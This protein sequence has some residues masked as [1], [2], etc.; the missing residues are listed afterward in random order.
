RINVCPFRLFIQC[1]QYLV[2]ANP[3]NFEFNFEIFVEVIEKYIIGKNIFDCEGI[4][5]E[6]AFEKIVLCKYIYYNSTFNGKISLYKKYEDTIELDSYEAS[7]CS[8]R[9]LNGLHDFPG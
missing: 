9:K 1:A 8:D 6:T 3:Q 7:H 5:Y 2:Y 4:F